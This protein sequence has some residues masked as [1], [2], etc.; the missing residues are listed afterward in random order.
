[1]LRATR[2]AVK[3]A[4]MD[5]R[6]IA[7]VGNIYA[8]EALWRARIDP[9]RPGRALRREEGRALYGAI[10]EVLT[11]AIEGGGTTFRDYR[12]G[13]GQPGSFQGALAVYGRHGEPCLR[14]GTRL[15]T[16]HA[17]DARATTICWRC[18]T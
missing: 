1:M 10:R 8:N 7:G 3:K 14:C 17:V 4:I 12:N 2:Q 5:Q 16:T 13:T 11:E 18:Q 6:R 9:S 15:H